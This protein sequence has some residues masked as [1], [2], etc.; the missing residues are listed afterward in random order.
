MRKAKSLLLVLVML[1]MI[2][3]VAGCG[4]SGTSPGPEQKDDYPTG[5]IELT[6]MF[7]P[8]G[9][10]DLLGRQ[11]ASYASEILGVPMPAVNRQGA[12][13]AVAF[14]HIYNEKPDG[15]SIISHSP[16]ISTSYYQGNMDFNYED[17]EHICMITTE[18]VSI[19]VAKD[20]PWNSINDLVEY[21]KAN[22]GKVK[23]GHSGVGS[24][25]H[26]AVVALENETGVSF[27]SIPYGGGSLAV[28][29]V[30]SGEI[31]ASSQLSAEVMA[32]AKAGEVKILGV[33]GVNRVSALPDVP[34]FQEQGIDLTL[35]LWRGFAA[36]KGTPVERI[37][38]LEETFKKVAENKGFI[39]FV[40]K[41]GASVE[42]MPKEEFDAFLKENDQLIGDIM[43]QIG[44]SKR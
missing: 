35:T 11:M 18:A 37:K 27:N 13:G 7:A 1:F 16:A 4:Q 8:G 26:L 44:M 3:I 43:K 41:M 20:A 40:E 42:F 36:P 25:T 29:D 39:E 15:Y 6:I 30:M 32:Q 5:P 10:A 33:T 19:A 22:P 28:T 31:H 2:G 17:F 38:V 24:F 23:V 21:A 12:G 14:T 34:T 9:G